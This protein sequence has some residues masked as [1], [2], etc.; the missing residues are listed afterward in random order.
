M[1]VLD[2]DAQP[3]SEPDIIRH[4]AEIQPEVVGL[5]CWTDFWYPAWNLAKLIK[6]HF[7]AIH[8]TMGG[9]HVGVFPAETLQHDNVDSIILGDGEAPTLNLLDHLERGVPLLDRG[10]YIKGNFL[11]SEML[12]YLES[13]LDRIPIIDRT[14]LP[15]ENYTSV[16][17]SRP[18]ITTMITQSR[19]SA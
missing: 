15:L 13:D 19:L 6:Q 8:I 14:L 5:S 7:P 9:P 12:F 10:V 3:L 1:A 16:L 4:L 11:P 18:Q 17:S 2:L